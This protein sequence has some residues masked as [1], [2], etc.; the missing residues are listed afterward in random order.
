[1]PQQRN[2]VDQRDRSER[3][4]GFI[5]LRLSPAVSSTSF[6]DV[7]DLR[8]LASIGGYGALL[9]VLDQYPDSSARRLITS[10]H[11]KESLELE[12]RAA[13]N[14][15]LPSH[16]ITSYWHIDARKINDP[17]RL[18]QLLK[19]LP[20]VDLVYRELSGSDPCVVA[21]DPHAVHQLHLLDAPIG[22]GA[23]WAW[24]HPC[25][26]GS[27]VAFVD[28]EMGWLFSHEDLPSAKVLPQV[29][30]DVRA[31][32]RNHGTG[33]LGIAVGVDNTVGIL[34]IA[35]KPA[36]MTVTSHYNAAT[37]TYGHVPAAIENVLPHMAAGDVLLI[38]WQ[39][40]GLIPAETVFLVWDQIR[41]AVAL[42]IVVVEAAG[43]GFHDL[44]TVPMFSD[45]GAILVGAC[46]STLDITGNAHD[47]L[48]FSNFGIASIAMRSVKTLSLVALESLRQ[49]SWIL[50][51]V[52]RTSIGRISVA[53]V[54]RRQLSLE[55]RSSSKACT[56]ASWVFHSNPRIF[57]TCF[58]PSG[59]I[60]APPLRATSGSCP[61]SKKLRES[62]H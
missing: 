25:G 2:G 36:W 4:N 23:R 51:L 12:R 22:V 61:I 14:G 54:E 33:V 47:R 30:H 46:A 38:E 43:N 52:R 31:A 60:R 15:F 41:K 20:E 18:V 3:Y 1:M 32:S 24:S 8:V 58:G 17:D 50:G 13:R 19:E 49:E 57:V 28:L 42:D 62:C 27:T 39:A 45:S 55:P 9:A 26:S 21:T 6:L 10:L 7:N 44:N 40:D 48:P 34:G 16:S 56:N 59:R 53:R 29:S 11:P 35:P 37:D 5:V